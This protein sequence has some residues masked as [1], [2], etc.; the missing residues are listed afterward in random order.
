MSQTK[1]AIGMVD[2]T[3]T[4]GSGN[5]LR[6]DGAWSAPTGGLVFISNS[7]LSS[8]ATYDFTSF[9][10]GSFEHY[11]FYLQNLIPSTDDVHLWCRTSTDGGSYYDDGASDYDWTI[12]HTSI[13]HTDA[14]VDQDL[15]SAQ[16]SLTGDHTSTNVT[17]G[18]TT[19]ESGVSGVIQLFGPHTTSYTHV[20]AH[21]IG[22][23]AIASPNVFH[24]TGVRLSAGDVDGFRLLFESGTIESGT[25]TAYGLVNA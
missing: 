5:F 1:V 4:P 15:A 16:I 22:I 6:G 2:A 17:I 8:A 14:L 11:Q 12:N 21:L 23:S 20:L 25:V 3:G 7:D 18:S 24:S 13:H 10:A 19:V 9:T